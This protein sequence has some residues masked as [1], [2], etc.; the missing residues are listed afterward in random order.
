MLKSKIPQKSNLT[1]AS[2]PEEL[3]RIREIEFTDQ[4]NTGR[5]LTEL[6]Q[7]QKNIIKG[8]GM[9]SLFGLK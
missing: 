7:N 9:K 8:I 1:T 2:A 5:Q 4:S 3:S 6:T